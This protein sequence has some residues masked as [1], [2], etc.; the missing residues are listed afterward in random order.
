MNGDVDVKKLLAFAHSGL[1][2]LRLPYVMP[3]VMICVKL[4]EIGFKSRP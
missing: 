1:I 4:Q 3:A 2:V